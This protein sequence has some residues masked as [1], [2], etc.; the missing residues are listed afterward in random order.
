MF[1]LFSCLCCLLIPIYSYFKIFTIKNINDFSDL[2]NSI[3][4]VHPEY[5]KLV[6]YKETLKLIFYKYKE[7]FLQYKFGIVKNING[8]TH[9]NYYKNH[10]LYTIIIKKNIKRNMII[11]DQNDEDVTLKIKRF[12]GFNND[13]H[14]M[15]ITPSDIGYD[16]LVFYIEDNDKLE[17]KENE[18]MRL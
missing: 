9:V 15:L 4:S 18:I 13:F 17:F 6:L 11:Y 3:K 2:K 10:T 1:L 14:G 8:N 16:K 12:L 5:N 7:E